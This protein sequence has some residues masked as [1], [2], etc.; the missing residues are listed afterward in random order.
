MCVNGRRF[1]RPMRDFQARHKQT[2]QDQEGL[3]TLG[4]FG[5]GLS[6]W[7][8]PGWSGLGSSVCQMCTMELA[9]SWPAPR[10][11]AS[12]DDAPYLYSL[13]DRRFAAVIR[14]EC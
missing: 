6:V 3:S 13:R 11:V 10:E 1:S 2:K 14:G 5:R 8:C 7:F 9:F 4:L 12:Q